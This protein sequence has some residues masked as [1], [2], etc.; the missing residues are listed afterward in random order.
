MIKASAYETEVS[1]RCE[2]LKALATA[3]KIIVEATS[4]AQTDSS[5]ANDYF[6]VL[7]T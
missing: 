2:E 6:E 4:L 3:K 5:K 7:K 1:S